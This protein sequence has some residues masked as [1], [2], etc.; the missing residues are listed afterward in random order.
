MSHSKR[1]AKR[2]QSSS[3]GKPQQSSR[4]HPKQARVIAM[5]QAPKGTTIAA[6]MKAT[7]WQPHSVRGFIS[8]TLG[9]KIGLSVESA[10]SESGE[11]TYSLKA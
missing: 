1:K 3:P 11:R 7:N 4:A 9:K 2:A 8:G 5:L 6:I 10:K